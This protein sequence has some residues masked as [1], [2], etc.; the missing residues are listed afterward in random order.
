MGI[1]ICRLCTGNVRDD[2]NDFS[3][4]V[5]NSASSSFLGITPS[6]VGS[7]AD[8]VRARDNT[9]TNLLRGTNNL[10]PM[11]LPVGAVGGVAND[12]ADAFREFRVR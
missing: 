3:E 12:G 6:I 4:G 2:A 8:F 11:S 9:A 7:V 10:I 5:R 1:G